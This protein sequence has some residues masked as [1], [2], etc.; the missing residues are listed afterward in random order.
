MS[1][2]NAALSGAGATMLLVGLACSPHT[3]A[4][5]RQSALEAAEAVKAPKPNDAARPSTPARAAE[6][7]PQPETRSAVDDHEWMLPVESWKTP[8]KDEVPISFVNRG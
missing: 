1:W 6:L 2:R 8:F 5:G 4:L 3:P 7:A